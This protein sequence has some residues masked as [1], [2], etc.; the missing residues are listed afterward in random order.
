MHDM[1]L[2]MKGE[3]DGWACGVTWP[4]KLAEKL[5]RAEWVEKIALV[6]PG[7]KDLALTKKSCQGRKK[8]EEELVSEKFRLFRL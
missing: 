2:A 7:G 4:G 3:L 6:E 5:D 1:E 8:R